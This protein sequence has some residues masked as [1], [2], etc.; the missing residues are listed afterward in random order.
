M[1]QASKRARG[2]SAYDSVIRVCSMGPAGMYDMLYLSQRQ[3][4]RAVTI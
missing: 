3:T 1:K 4:G 2:G